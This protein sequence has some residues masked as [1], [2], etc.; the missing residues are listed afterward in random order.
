[1]HLVQPRDVHAKMDGSH[2]KSCS[3][4]VGIFKSIFKTILDKARMFMMDTVAGAYFNAKVF[5][6][7]RLSVS[8]S[9][10]V[11]SFRPPRQLRCAG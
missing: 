1:M 3:S 11:K 7:A 8:L 4:G 2:V 5:E 6:N 9:F 10:L